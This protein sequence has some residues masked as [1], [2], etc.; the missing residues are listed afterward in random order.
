MRS[1]IK[2]LGIFIKSDFHP[3]L[4]LYFFIFLFVAIWFNYADSPLYRTIFNVNVT[5]LERVLR[6]FL[7]FSIPWF[8]IAIPRLVVSKKS[9]VIKTGGFYVCIV[10]ILLIISF[11]SASV[12]FNPF[13]KYADS[14]D[15]QLYLSK[16]L[17]NLQGLVILLLLMI[18]IKLSRKKITFSDTGLRLKDVNLKP[19]FILILAIVPMIIWA[20]F[21]A[22][23][24]AT[25]PSYKPWLY[26][27]LFKIPK[28]VTAFI[29]EFLYG[30]DFLTIEFTFRGLLVILMAR[31]IGKDAVLP[32]AAVYCFLHFGKPGIEA[33]SSIFGGYFLGVVAL[34]SRSIAP[35]Y[36]LHLSLAWLMD[37]AAYIQHYIK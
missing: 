13:I 15:Q 1:V 35:G 2:D 20:S 22:E 34:N 29:Y 33:I 23:F 17:S 4:Y 6:F 27:V 16:I 26:P 37:F 9:D 24:I 18:F 25:Y 8:L 3:W 21:N 12:L 10:L 19:F 30:I 28:I 5:G 14:F 31:Y 36:I 32:M 7:Y 11:D